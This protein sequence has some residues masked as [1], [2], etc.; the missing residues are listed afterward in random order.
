MKVLVTCLL[1]F[2]A[3]AAHADAG[4]VMAR[5]ELTSCG[6]SASAGSTFLALTVGEPVVG[7]A[8]AFDWSA[9]AGFW[10]MVTPVLLVDVPGEP[11]GPALRYALY[12]GAPNPSPGHA[13]IRY[14]IPA[15]AAGGVRVT[16]RVFDVSGRLVR[17]LEDGPRAPGEHA[18][19]W[20][21]RDRSGARVGA[22]VYVCH[23]QAGGFVAT[24]RLVVIR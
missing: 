8:H 24:R 17:V 15:A 23:M 10:A 18:V 20:D 5:D 12:P 16:L 3:A 4:F 9:T 19:V 22:G 14:V 13:V 7:T 6:G 1:L 11:G 2:P 21:G